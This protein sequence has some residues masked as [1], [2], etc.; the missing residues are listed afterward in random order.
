MVH[1]KVYL[2]Y[3]FTF[4]L[5]GQRKSEIKVKLAS[6]NRLVF[7]LLIGYLSRV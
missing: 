7:F 1:R 3:E 4:S 2:I 6:F 5:L